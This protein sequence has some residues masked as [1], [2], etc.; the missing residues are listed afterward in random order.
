[1][2]ERE[3]ARHRA[4][5]LAAVEEREV[6]EGTPTPEH[7]RA[8]AEWFDNPNCSERLVV[9]LAGAPLT[10][11][12]LLRRIAEVLAATPQQGERR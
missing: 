8:L 6:R 4:A 2:D 9:V 12:Y 11:G 10:P 7:L 5:A 1:M 3:N